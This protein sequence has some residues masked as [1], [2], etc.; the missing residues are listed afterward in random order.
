MAFTLDATIGGSASNSYITQADAEDVFSGMLKTQRWNEASSA[1]KDSALA[2]S[3]HRI[4]A[5]GFGGEKT[6]S[7]QS[8]QYPRD[9][10]YDRDG[11]TISNSIIPSELERATCALA[12]YMLQED[13]RSA[14]QDEIDDLESY[15]VGPLQY[16]IRA[17]RSSSDLPPTVITLLAAI[18]INAYVLGGIKNIYR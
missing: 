14:A 15:K 9:Y 16:D 6:A 5:E 10:I 18:G 17:T 11:N 12:L 3:T 4:D 2:Q 7:A 8:L 13:D 1:D